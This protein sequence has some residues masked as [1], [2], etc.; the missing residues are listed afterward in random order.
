MVATEKENLFAIL[1]KKKTS[2]WAKA[3]GELLAFIRSTFTINMT[4]SSIVVIFD[5]SNDHNPN[6]L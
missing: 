6:W 1:K 5:L 3:G 2:L 4:A